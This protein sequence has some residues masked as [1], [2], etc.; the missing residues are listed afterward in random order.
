MTTN[1]FAYTVLQASAFP[2]F[3]YLQNPRDLH[4]DYD[5]GLLLAH[6][7]SCKKGF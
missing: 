3:V 5:L 6:M 1:L 2:G 7:M 4:Q